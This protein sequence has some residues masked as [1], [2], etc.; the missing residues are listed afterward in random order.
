MGSGFGYVIKHLKVKEEELQNNHFYWRLNE[1][2]MGWF[3]FRPMFFDAPDAN[4]HDRDLLW[5]NT[6]GFR[7]LEETGDENV[8]LVQ[9]GREKFAVITK[10]AFLELAN[11]LF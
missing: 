7:A 9:K 5:R 3:G 8:V 1:V 2:N 11:L 4:T 6:L 10:V